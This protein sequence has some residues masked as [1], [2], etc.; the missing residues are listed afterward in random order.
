[1]AWRALGKITR[2]ST[3]DLYAHMDYT[4][5]INFSQ[6]EDMMLFLLVWPGEV[7]INET[8]ECIINNGSDK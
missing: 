2:N 3:G 8:N 4:A 6:R 7:L 5:I 1:L